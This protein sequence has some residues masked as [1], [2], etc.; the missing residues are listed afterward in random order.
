[1]FCGRSE[2]DFDKVAGM[3]AFFARHIDGVAKFMLM[4]LL[5]YADFLAFSRRQKSISG[6]D[7]SHE[8]DGYILT[9]L[10]EV[11]PYSYGLSLKAIQ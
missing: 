5:W 4:K 2:F 10:T 6:M 3:M 11:I 1:M 8:E 7:I 9:G